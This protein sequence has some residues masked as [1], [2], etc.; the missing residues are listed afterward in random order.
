[1]TTG[2]KSVIKSDFAY[3]LSLSF[4]RKIK[5]SRRS[6][7]DVSVIDYRLA[8]MNLR[9]LGHGVTSIK[10][11]FTV[12][13]NQ[14]ITCQPLLSRTYNQFWLIALKVLVIHGFYLCLREST[15]PSNNPMTGTVSTKHAIHISSQSFRPFP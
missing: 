11:D 8:S 14:I 9:T 12:S 6:R 4:F 15:P 2:C 13:P 10:D 5:A 1:M 7:K 3:G